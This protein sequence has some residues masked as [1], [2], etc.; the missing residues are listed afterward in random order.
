MARSFGECCCD[1]SR[2]AELLLPEAHDHQWV[3]VACIW[4]T[5]NDAQRDKLTV[6]FGV[7]DVCQKNKHRTN[8][9]LAAT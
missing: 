2:K 3:E 8:Y 4:W 9:A 6:Y 5:L 7:S 1:G